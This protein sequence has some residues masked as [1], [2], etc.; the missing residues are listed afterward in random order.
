LQSGL[1]IPGFCWIGFSSYSTIC[2]VS[3]NA[4][5]VNSVVDMPLKYGLD[6]T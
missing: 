2:I 1:M 5:P 4:L 6:W 3:M